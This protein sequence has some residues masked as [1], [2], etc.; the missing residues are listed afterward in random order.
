MF[1]PLNDRVL[2]QPDEGQ[3]K[4]AG[5]IYIPDSAKERPLIGTVVAAGPGEYANGAR[6]PLA[7]KEG[8]RVMFG[9]YSGGDIRIGG[10]DY[11]I[12]KEGEIFGILN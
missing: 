2:I 4:T 5:G 12:A 1:T 8:D 3:G 9:R 6:R 7:V 11:L 10:V